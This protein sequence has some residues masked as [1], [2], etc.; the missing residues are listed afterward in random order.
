MDVSRE[1]GR[2]KQRAIS[3]EFHTGGEF[4]V[5]GAISHN[6]HKYEKVH[7]II[8]HIVVYPCVTNCNSG[9]AGV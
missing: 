3:D 8:Y 7:T 5:V 2:G 6:S 9:F 1:G 4:E